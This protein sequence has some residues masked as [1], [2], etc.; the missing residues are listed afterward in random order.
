MT[1]GYKSPHCF[2]NV[3]RLPREYEANTNSWMNTN[4]VE[5]YLT[6]L[7]RKL[8][9]KNLLLTDQCAANLK[10]TTF[11]RN[12]KVA[13]L[14]ATAFIQIWESSVHSTVVTESS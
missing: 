12:M 7:D 3:N 5:D 10:N 1:V 11:F 14:P 4:I 8:G 6:Q 9:A 13:F 2:K